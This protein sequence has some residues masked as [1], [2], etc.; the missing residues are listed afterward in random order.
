MPRYP[1]SVRMEALRLYVGEEISAAAVA[2][3]LR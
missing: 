2:R 3:R 1:A